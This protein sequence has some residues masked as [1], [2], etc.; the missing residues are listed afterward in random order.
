MREVYCNALW[1]KIIEVAKWLCCGIFPCPRLFHPSD[2]MWERRDM[3]WTNETAVLVLSFKRQNLT[4]WS[5]STCQCMEKSLQRKKSSISKQLKHSTIADEATLSY[6]FMLWILGKIQVMLIWH[7][8]LSLLHAVFKTRNVKKPLWF[9]SVATVKM[10]NKV[11][12]SGSW[13]ETRLPVATVVFLK[14]P[15]KMMNFL[16]NYIVPMKI[17]ITWWEG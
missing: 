17:P 3:I 10:L 8:F 14:V 11:L 5:R 1:K 7:F 4:P 15:L 12:S 13:N 9:A 16:K 6:S 2:F